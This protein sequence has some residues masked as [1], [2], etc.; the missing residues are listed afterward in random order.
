LRGA[1]AGVEE[2]H[3]VTGVVRRFDAPRAAENRPR[4][5]RRR[6]CGPSSRAR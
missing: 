5:R 2:E 3:L 6:T 4:A 1:L